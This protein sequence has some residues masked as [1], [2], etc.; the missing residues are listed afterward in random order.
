MRIKKLTSMIVST[1]SVV[2]MVAGQPVWAS[3]TASADAAG[4]QTITD[5]ADT[6]SVTLT[7]PVSDKPSEEAIQEALPAEITVYLDGSDQPVDIPVTWQDP[8]G[9]YTSS[10]YYYYEFD[11][12]WDSSVYTLAAGEEVPVAWIHLTPDSS[13][14]I[15]DPE[16]SQSDS[17]SA[18]DQTSTLSSSESETDQVSVQSSNAG[19][20]TETLLGANED[21]DA[22][23]D[24]IYQY[25]TGTMGLNSAAACGVLANIYA[26]SSFRADV[27]AV[28]I[29][30]LMSFGICQW[31]ASRFDNL[32]QYASDTGGDYTSLSTQLGFLNYELT[33]NSYYASILDEIRSVSNDAAGAASAAKTWCI[34]FEV[35]ANAEAVAETRADY[36]VDMFWP[37]YGTGSSTTRFYDVSSKAFYADAVNW[38]ADQGITTGTGNGR[39]SPNKGCTRGQIITFL[40]HLAGSPVS[41]TET[42]FVDV[43]PSAFYSQAVSWALAKGI[44]KGTDDTH[45]SPDEPC[46]RAMIIQFLYVY[47]GASASELNIFWDV[48]TYDYFANACTWAVNNGITG[49]TGKDEYGHTYFS[50][51]DVC[52]RAQAVTFLYKYSQL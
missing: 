28:D 22:N 6:D 11:P 51:N 9:I 25:L 2:T 24:Q 17:D 48:E 15:P 21:L 35:P 43:N 39:F 36:A 5:F 12:V 31:H 46:T 3:G 19:E 40:W 37:M 41:S 27:G 34:K 29:D 26:E 44:T 47:A 14:I 23:R 33:T 18:S 30:G 32:Q 50:P 1:V 7:Y 13:V 8:T 16:T 52:T 10:N 4:T 49:G 38:A 45:F 20:T 42:K